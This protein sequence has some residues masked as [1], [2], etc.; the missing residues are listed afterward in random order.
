MLRQVLPV[1]LCVLLIGA[2]CKD[3]KKGLG[4]STRGALSQ[5]AINDVSISTRT[6]DYV[7]C[8]EAAWISNANTAKTVVATVRI[9]SGPFNVPPNTETDKTV[10]VAPGGTMELGCGRAKSQPHTWSFR[11]VGASY[12]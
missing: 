7:N 9:R 3:G 5:E 8:V 12:K 11:A 1:V 6:V 2:G 4:A 10:E